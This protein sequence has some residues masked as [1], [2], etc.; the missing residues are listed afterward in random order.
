MLSVPPELFKKKEAKF[1]K[2]TTRTKHSSGKTVKATAKA[3][4][5]YDLT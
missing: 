2:R 1:R 3:E 5:D 4:D